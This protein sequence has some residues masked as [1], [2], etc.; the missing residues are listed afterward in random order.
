MDLNVKKRLYPY[1][2]VQ[3]PFLSDTKKFIVDGYSK[4]YYNC[5]NN[6]RLVEKWNL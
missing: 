1:T 5:N 2:V 4:D 3:V 6:V